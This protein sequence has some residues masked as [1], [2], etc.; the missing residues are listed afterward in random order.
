VTETGPALKNA[1]RAVDNDE[2]NLGLE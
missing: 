2:E 1:G